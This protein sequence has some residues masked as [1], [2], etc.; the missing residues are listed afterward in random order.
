[1]ESI[2][3]G[4][5]SN[6][7]EAPFAP[8]IPGLV[9]YYLLFI[10]IIV[11]VTVANLLV[12]IA[13][14]LDRTTSVYVRF[15][16]CNIPLSCLVVSAGILL[17]NS[18]GLSLIIA[19]HHESIAEFC[20]P[21]LYLVSVG[22][23]GQLLFL[24]VFSVNVYITVNHKKIIGALKAKKYY[25][26]FF[27]GSV[28]FVWFAV[29]LSRIVVFFTFSGSTHSCRYT[30]EGGVG[31]VVIDILVY[32]VGGFVVTNVFLIL[33]VCY[34]KH[35]T[36]SHQESAFKKAMVK[37]SFFLLLSNAFTFTGLILPAILVVSTSSEQM[38]L[39]AYVAFYIATVL[40]NLSLVPTPIL[41]IAFF[42]PVRMRLKSWCCCCCRKDDDSDTWHKRLDI[43]Y[44]NF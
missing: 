26:C 6:S 4:N 8:S 41:I 23:T 25:L 11:P 19:G 38:T 7:T 2:N 36:Y 15:S 40:I 16:L 20:V 28:L 34:T 39:A 18:A 14:F 5:I 12:L 37:L 33:T 17:Y 21:S 1:M 10:A 3:T 30:R 24:A 42:T 44:R 27:I 22:G 9:V 35:H 29:I 13:I 32:G 31:N 43:R